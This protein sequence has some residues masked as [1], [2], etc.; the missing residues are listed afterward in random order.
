MLKKYF[1]FMMLTCLSFLGICYAQTTNIPDPEFE[2]ALIDLG[3][4]S[5]GVVNQEVLTA[6]ISGVSTLN[7]NSKNISDLTGIEDFSSLVF[8]DCSNNELSTLNVNENK[9][10]EELI[11]FFNKLTLLQVS[12]ASALEILKCENNALSGL[13]VSLNKN[14]SLLNCNGNEL[15]NLNVSGANRLTDL[16]CIGNNLSAIDISNNPEIINFRCSDNLL[17]TLDISKNTGLQYFYCDRNQLSSINLSSNPMLLELDCHDNRINVLDVGFNTD[18]VI[19]RC[20]ENNIEQLDLSRHPSVKVIECQDNDLIDFNLKNGNNDLITEFN[21]RDNA[22]LYCV[23]VDNANYSQSNW[24]Q[25]DPWTFFSEDCTAPVLPPVAVDD[26][27]DTMTN[28]QLNVS[29]ANGVLSNDSDPQGIELTAVL[30]GDVSNGILILNPDGSFTYTPVSVFT[31]TDSFTYLNNNGS[32][33]SAT[34]TVKIN[35]EGRTDLSFI[36]IPNAF[37]PNGDGIND[38]FK[39]VYSGMRI[40]RMEIYN[41]WGNLIY[42]EENEDLKGWN[43]FVQNKPAENGNYLYKISALTNLDEEILEE[44][45]F[46]LIR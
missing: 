18:I 42:A 15:E 21:C 4:D 26:T 2:Q 28:T 16:E 25:K 31:G 45:I 27:Y 1:L 36:E 39:P 43:G 7:V 23:Q 30:N 19:L 5:D 10:L 8:L 40:V 14:L 46:S 12:G 22:D 32:L 41:T 9:N 17:S 24:S 6:D 34:A 11:C 3:I 38:F 44:D 33:N 13:D 35:I 29:A 20:H 37:T